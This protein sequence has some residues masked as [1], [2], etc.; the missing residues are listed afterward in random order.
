VSEMSDAGDCPVCLSELE[1]KDG[2]RLLSCMHV[3]HT[4]CIDGWLARSKLCPTCK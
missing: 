2:V 4:G 3:F 1:A